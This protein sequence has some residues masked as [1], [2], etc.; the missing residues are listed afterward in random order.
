M[1]NQIKRY[2]FHYQ[3]YLYKVFSK[4]MLETAFKLDL[5]RGIDLCFYIPSHKE[6][7]VSRG[8]NQA[9]LLAGEIARELELELSH[10][11]L[12]KVKKTREQNKLEGAQ[13]RDNLIGA[14]AYESSRSLEGKSILLIDDIVTT[15]STIKES[16]KLLL[17][18]GA[19][20]IRAFALTSSKKI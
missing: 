3:N 2:K 18:R 16:S 15:G 17:D 7:L 6:K 11:E 4:I 5:S 9:E 12:I 13:R 20:E 8:Y 1:R 10:G 14:Y 19:K